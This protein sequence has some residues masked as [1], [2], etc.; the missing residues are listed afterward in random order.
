MPEPLNLSSRDVPCR[1][2]FLL[3]WERNRK[4]KGGGDRRAGL[5]RK[6]ALEA[7]WF[8]GQ[9]SLGFLS[10]WRKGVSA[11]LQVGR[12]LSNYRNRT[13]FPLP[14]ATVYGAFHVSPVG[15]GDF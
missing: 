5:P 15:Q 6:H 12:I 14:R 8:G 3:P 2:S 9:S 11:G 4:V 13:T 1:C 10:L 7:A